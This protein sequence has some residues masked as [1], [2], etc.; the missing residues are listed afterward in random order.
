MKK[1]ILFTTLLLALSFGVKANATS[2]L[3]AGQ[4]PWIY[5]F[6]SSLWFYCQSIDDSVWMVNG[7]NSF[8]LAPPAGFAPA[9]VEGRTFVAT[10]SEGTTTIQFLA[11]NQYTESNLEGTSSGTYRYSKNGENTALLVF[12]ENSQ[13]ATITVVDVTFASSS[14]GTAAGRT[15]EIDGTDTV[16]ATFVL[17]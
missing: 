7:A 1:S 16:S 17:Q 9:S 11:N 6:D 14:S 13:W 2:W 4:S 12:L 3:Y 5:D 8:V 10:T 15:T